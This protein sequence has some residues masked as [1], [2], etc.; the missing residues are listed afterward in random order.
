MSI[1][2]I[3]NSTAAT[4]DSRSAVKTSSGQSAAG[5]AASSRPASDQSGIT[6]ARTDAVSISTQAADLQALEARIRDLPDVDS[7]R[8]TELRDKI[9]SGQYNVDSGR[10]AD[11]ILA[12]EK[13]F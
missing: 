11:R 13:S 7:G 4:S 1:P 10:L 5:S 3:S 2:T 6:Q 8:V 9:S 12:F